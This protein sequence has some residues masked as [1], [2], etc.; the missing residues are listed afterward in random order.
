MT[1]PDHFPRDGSSRVLI[2]PCTVSNPHACGDHLATNRPD[3]LVDRSAGRVARLAARSTGKR[4]LRFRHSILNRGEPFT[5][6]PS[7]DRRRTVRRIPRHRCSSDA[8]GRGH[9][10]QSLSSYSRG[11]DSQLAPACVRRRNRGM[12]AFLVVRKA[13]SLHFA[14][15]AARAASRLSHGSGRECRRR[16]RNPGHCSSA[17]EV[18][19]LGDG[20]THF[21]A[22]VVCRGAARSRRHPMVCGGSDLLRPDRDEMTRP[23]RRAHPASWLRRRLTTL[24]WWSWWYIVK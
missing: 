2:G 1:S 9:D 23:S 10:D 7:P 11:P 20:R 15:Y 13:S 8:H 24:M 12:L 22:R 18:V 17:G 14:S 16:S 4:R 3:D 5:H 19:P 21:M 6:D